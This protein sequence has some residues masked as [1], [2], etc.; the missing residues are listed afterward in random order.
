MKAAQFAVVPLARAQYLRQSR[1]HRI[2][3]HLLHL[4]LLLQPPVLIHQRLD[5]GAT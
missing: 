1:V 2:D 4:H 3:G 5:A